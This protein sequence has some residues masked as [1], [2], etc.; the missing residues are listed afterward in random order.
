MALL[1][2]K[3][4]SRA[5]ALMIG[6]RAM[7]RFCNRLTPLKSMKKMFLSAFAVAALLFV[8]CTNDLTEENLAGGA[9]AGKPM[10]SSLTANLTSM[11][12]TSLESPEEGKSASTVWSEGDVI[13]VVTESG[14]VRQ[15][16]LV[17]GAGTTSA[18]F[19]IQGEEGDVYTYAFYPYIYNG[20]GKCTASNVNGTP[21][22]G[23]IEFNFPVVQFHK[24]GSVFGE[25]ANT[26]VGAISGKS[27]SLQSVM[28][29]LEIR[30]K[31]SQTV[32]GIT[33]K[34]SNYKHKI[35][36]PGTVDMSTMEPTM[37][38]TNASF[39]YIDLE[40]PQGVQLNTTTATSFY[41][42][43]PAGTYEN[44]SV[45]VITADGSY[46]R[47]STKSHTVSPREI[48]P[49]NCGNLD[50]VID[51]ANAID[52][53][54]GKYSNCYIV[55]PEAG[56]EKT[57]SFDI[58]RVDG[59]VVE[60][61]QLVSRYVGEEATF[62]NCATADEVAPSFAHIVWAEDLGVAYDVHFDKVAG[63]VYF[64]NKAVGNARIMVTM[65][66]NGCHNV[67]GNV[68]RCDIS[69]IWGWHIWACNEQ[70]K[71]VMTTQ[72]YAAGGGSK[73]ADNNYH[74]TREQIIAYSKSKPLGFLD[75][76][77]GA[78]YAP[79]SIEDV[80]NMT[81]QQ[82]ADALGLYFQAGNLH[83]YPRP[84]KFAVA[85]GGWDGWARAVYQYGFHQYNQSWANS[86]SA[87]TSL[88]D[89]WHY[90]YYAYSASYTPNDKY[91]TTQNR[92]SWVKM[93]IGLGGTA[94]SNPIAL[95]GG[96]GAKLNYDPCP[97]GY[98]VPHQGN[99]YQITT[100]Q[101]FKFSETGAETEVDAKGST[102]VFTPAKKV[103][104]QTVGN[105]ITYDGQSID[106]HPAGGYGGG[107]KITWNKTGNLSYLWGT[108]YSSGVGTDATNKALNS[109]VK[110]CFHSTPSGSNY[111]QLWPQCATPYQIRCI[112][113]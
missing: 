41:I 17:E 90:P 65:N 14:A 72:P 56:K 55:V 7:K 60:N 23:S 71:Q 31:G 28:G 112:K 53:C 97:K 4:I 106:F 62:P 76:N 100:G 74:A 49:L 107:G 92:T 79:K 103:N 70:P 63:K 13:G 75:R 22:T 99:L 98:K 95:W 32:Y 86:S 54:G 59:T 77:I 24:E 43:V 52:L 84:Q 102:F 89:N 20:N 61:S 96:S 40:V 3:G 82:A 18:A 94:T 35:S 21:E 10:I 38:T 34:N 69:M 78:T 46:T 66:P 81:D 101:A 8:G 12:R 16:T 67:S 64:K 39:S 15:A 68:L 9:T 25:N 33:L 104:D 87:K 50:E 29:A 6:S 5:R 51:K 80:E 42:L 109:A 88:E 83:P 48:L 26:M 111:T 19:D 85:T 105:Y 11:T 27:V 57:Y 36:G 47:T 93:D 73:G 58:K 108:P 113:E 1:H 30:L 44:F 45:G 91:S 110:A 2:Q 37:G